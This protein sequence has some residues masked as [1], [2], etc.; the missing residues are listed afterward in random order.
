MRIV[1]PLEVPLSSFFIS[2]ISHHYVY[3]FLLVW[4]SFSCFFTYLVIVLCY[5]GHSEC[6]FVE[7]WILLFSF[8]ECWALFL[9]VVKLPVD[10]LGPFKTS[11]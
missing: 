3:V 9:Q 8:K 4:V 7:Y 6:D 5:A 10:P 1:S 11:F 2:Y